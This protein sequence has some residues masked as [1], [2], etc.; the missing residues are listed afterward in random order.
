MFQCG[1]SHHFTQN[2]PFEVKK[3]NP[4][5]LQKILRNEKPPKNKDAMRRTMP[6]TPH[7]L[8]LN[9][10]T[11]FYKTAEPFFKTPVSG[12]SVFIHT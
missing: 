3:T 7:P 1:F 12:S 5:R 11:I 2:R 10:K 9:L 8:L 6:H 4:N